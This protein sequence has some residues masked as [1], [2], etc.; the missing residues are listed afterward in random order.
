MHCTAM[1]KYKKGEMDVFETRRLLIRPFKREDL[2][3]FNEY[4][5]NPDVGPSAGWKPHESMDESFAVLI[6]L[7]NHQGEFALVLKATGKVIGS[8]GIS[9]DKK[10]F[11]QS[12]Y[13]I[14]YSLS[15]DYWG[16]GFAFEAMT[17]IMPYGFYGLHASILTIY[18]FPENRKSKSV[19][20]QCG[21]HYE[22][23]LRKFFVLYDGSLKDSCSYSMT[24]EEYRALADVHIVEIQSHHLKPM[25]RWEQNDELIIKAGIEI[26]RNQNEFN[27]SYQD[28]FEGKKPHLKLY[29][30]TYFK[31]LVGRLELF[32]QDK[33]YVGI[34]IDPLFQNQGFA[35]QALQQLLE[36]YQGELY[37]EVYQDNV[38]SIHVFQSFGF[39]HVSSKEEWYRGEVR[40]LLTFY[41][42]KN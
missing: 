31:R 19:I 6:N 9:V 33:V 36:N 4:A 26:K 8:I 20:D 27:Q 22:G 25:F 11:N 2:F 29:G 23:T 28:Y 1:I 13:V 30:I 7:I 42:H 24:R 18:H 14:G 41:Y 37:A 38:V 32:T 21:F 35:K 17:I 40:N 15:K 16:Q 12:S 39:K 34:V 10:R 5:T 3:D